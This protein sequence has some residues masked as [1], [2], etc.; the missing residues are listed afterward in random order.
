MGSIIVF[1][2]LL[3]GFFIWEY[4]FSRAAKLFKTIK[5]QE[6]ETYNSLCANSILYPSLKLKGVIAQNQYNQIQ[7]E[8]LKQELLNIDEKEAK[9]SVFIVLAIVL[10]FLINLLFKTLA[11]G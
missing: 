5:T 7:S 1:L 2:L 4:N 6:P 3:I 11:N 8:S 9:H 10:Y